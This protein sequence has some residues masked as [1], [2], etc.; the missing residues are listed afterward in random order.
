MAAPA[1]PPVH[2]EVYVNG[3]PRKRNDFLSAAGRTSATAAASR[4]A[5][6]D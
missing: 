4:L 3:V 6:G 5:T 2:L 1:G